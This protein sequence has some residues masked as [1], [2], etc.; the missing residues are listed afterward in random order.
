MTDALG[1]VCDEQREGKKS[2]S[3]QFII[4]TNLCSAEAIGQS[5]L[6]DS[7]WLSLHDLRVLFWLEL[8]AFIISSSLSAYILTSISRAF[9]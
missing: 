1:H 2:E 4:P 6:S 3:T 9:T 7:G 5:T 8:G